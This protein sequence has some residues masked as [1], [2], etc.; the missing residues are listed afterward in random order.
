MS[1]PDGRL[2]GKRIVLT[3]AASGMG[4]AC[5]ELFAEQ[6]ATLFLADVAADELEET[7]DRIGA[8]G[9]VAGTAVTDVSS[10]DA[11]VE[12]VDTAAATL[13][14]I[15]GGVNW[16]GISD[17]P[18][19]LHECP[20]ELWDRIIGV[21]LDGSFHVAKAIVPR[22]VET[23][24]SLVLISSIAGFVA[25]PGHPA[26]CA[27]KGGVLMLGRSLAVEYASTGV[28][29]NCLCPGSIDTPMLEQIVRDEGT[30]RE[31]LLRWEPSG[32]FGTPEEVCRAALFL[33]SD[34]ASY[35]NGVGLV[36]DGG[37]SS[38]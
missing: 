30:T 28:R 15:D 14:G 18:V 11:V 2:T 26:Y 1:S 32:R 21:N 27:S 9:D 12:L 22:L 20:I 38:T 33:M 6:G 10:Y 34:D 7:A 23:R 19:P 24:G 36:V 37:F 31:E 13:G 35:V 16:A 3:G 8:E 29:V 4:R 25:W 5:A 17:P